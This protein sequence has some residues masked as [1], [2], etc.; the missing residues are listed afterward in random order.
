MKN[1]LTIC[2]ALCAALL[3]TAC[4]KTNN[5][6]PQ[7]QQLRFQL[8]VGATSAP[9]NGPRRIATNGETMVTT[10]T[11]N[12]EAGVFAVR[13]GEIL[14]Q[15][16][17]L[18]LT[19]NQNGVWAPASVVPYSEEYEDAIFYAYYPYSDTVTIDL[20]SADVFGQVIADFAPA[21]DQSTAALFG[22][23]DLMTTDACRIGALH[24]V[25]LPMQHRMAMVTVEL[26][27]VSYIFTNE[28]IAPYVLVSPTN[29]KFM[30]EQGGE[31]KP[32]FDDA[33]LT[34]QLIL[35]PELQDKLIVSYDN[36]G[37]SERE[38]IDQIAN[39]W[40]GEY[41]R[42][43]I[44]GGASVTTM[45]LQPGDYFLDDGTLLSKDATEDEL[46]AVKSNIVGVVAYLGTTEAIAQAKSTCTHAS[47]IAT[48]EQRAAWGTVSSTSSD[49][50]A[51]GWRYWYR[52]K[53][54]TTDISE[55]DG[56]S[57]PEQ[58]DQSALVANG[59]ENT[60]VWRS[61][62]VGYELGGY[63]VDINSVFAATDEAYLTAHP[64]P[65]FT[66]AWYIPSLKEWLNIRAND[67]ALSASL[68]RIGATDF[69]WKTS[70]Q[71]Y[72]SSNIR[73]AAVFWGFT[74]IGSSST[75]LFKTINSK[76]AANYRYMLAF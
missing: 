74:G 55:A 34:Y 57:K 53:G 47:V 28:D 49:E 30:L 15:V 36:A 9:A 5:D 21:A 63:V 7:P 17:N 33:T 42:F 39:I 25:T 14:P 71:N 19:Y 40:A 65:A 67:Q 52:D 60:L 23:A 13:G 69:Q 43:V 44:D 24:S 54:F 62:P 48:T 46:N 27:N 1:Y 56:I 20:A 72:W 18:K 10:F 26:P 45:T 75:E 61:I 35:K 16:N 8:S 66:T 76:T 68:T 41:A 38:E 12:D 31:L 50:N 58:I 6:E 4:S 37:A 22:Q 32:H 2:I 64:T 59:Y 11:V 70:Q 29:V 3:T 73:T 51:A